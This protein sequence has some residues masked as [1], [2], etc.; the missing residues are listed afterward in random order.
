MTDEK[1]RMPQD[2]YLHD[3]EFHLMVD[4]L[5]ALI[6]DEQYTPSE[7]REAVILAVTHY[8]NKTIIPRLFTAVDECSGVIGPPPN[9][10]EKSVTT[11]FIVVDESS[12]VTDDQ[13][14]KKGG[15]S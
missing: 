15:K 1:H 10:K 3:N 8:N 13:W 2:R 5:E 12:D 6:L 14:E 7:L 4:F 11:R 9:D